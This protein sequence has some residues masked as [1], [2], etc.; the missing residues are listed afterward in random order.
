MG[1][2]ARLIWKAGLLGALLTAA[3]NFAIYEAGRLS[4]VRFGLHSDGF[5]AEVGAAQ[6][7]TT[8]LVTFALGTALAVLVGRRGIWQLRALQALGVA[9]AVV[10]AGAPL[11]MA[12]GSASKL[13]LLLMHLV[14]GMAYVAVLEIVNRSGS[15]VDQPERL[16]EGSTS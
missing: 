14:A 12:E 11:S 3:V 4:G 13:L 10:T 7:I 2:S 9:A 6:V 1:T 8:S 15:K 16:L 5:A